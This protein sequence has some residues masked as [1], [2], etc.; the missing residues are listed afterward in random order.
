MPPVTS[1]E[2]GRGPGECR[3][4]VVASRFNAYIVDR[5]LDGCLRTLNRRGVPPERITVIRVPGAYEIPVTAAALARK[6]DTDAVIALGAV[7]RGET[8]H[9]EHIATECARG[10][11]AA[12]LEYRVP[13]IFGVLTVETAAQAL[14]RSGDDESNKG[15]EAAAAALDM[16]G[17]MRQIG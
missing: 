6:G 2:A 4:G 17:I 8:A 12:A 13:V 7:I 9:F 5:L 14:D 3:I 1:I 10:L 11:G 16:I 15:S